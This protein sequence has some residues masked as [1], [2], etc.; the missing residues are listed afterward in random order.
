MAII[1]FSGSDTANAHGSLAPVYSVLAIA[2]PSQIGWMFIFTR[3]LAAGKRRKRV[4]VFGGTVVLFS[5]HPVGYAL[6]TYQ[7]TATGCAVI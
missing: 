6:T 7:T 1:R 4:R 3:K 5:E 2:E